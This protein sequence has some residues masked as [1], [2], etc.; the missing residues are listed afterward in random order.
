MNLFGKILT[1]L[2]LIM[3]IVF[4]AFTMMTYSTHKNWREAH[5]KVQTQLN[6][7]QDQIR[8]KQI[9]V[10]R[11]GIEIEYERAARAKALASLEQKSKGLSDSLEAEEAKA[12]IL[13]TKSRLSEQTA[14]T[15]QTEMERLKNEVNALRQGLKDAQQ[16]TNEKLRLAS[17]L[18]DRLNQKEG[19]LKRVSERREALRQQ[20]SRAK[21]VLDRNGLNEFSPV[22]DIP[23]DLD[24]VVTAVHESNLI[25]VSLGSDEGIQSGHKLDIYRQD[26]SYIGRVLV[27]DTNSDRSVGRIIPEYRQGV[28][29]RGDRVATQ[30]L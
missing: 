27:T 15:A 18:A 6:G 3:S 12:Q 28:I 26:G 24:G 16:A 25:E 19:E 22:D 14:Q 11:L 30:L 1:M 8:Q 7:V 4:M 23:P 13:Q 2:I 5:S 9:E 17:Q 29:R 10:D 21:L 20:L